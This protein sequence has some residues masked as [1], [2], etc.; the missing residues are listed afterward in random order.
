MTK[1][2]L[3]KALSSFDDNETVWIATPIKKGFNLSQIKNIEQK[4]MGLYI[5]PFK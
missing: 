1:K 5:I 3:I 4:A 2:E